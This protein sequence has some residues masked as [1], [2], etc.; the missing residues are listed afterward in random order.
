MTAA[1]VAR[2]HLAAKNKERPK[3]NPELRSLLP[4]LSDSERTK[5][6]NSI[7]VDG[8][9]EYIVVWQEQNV[10]VEGHNRQDICDEIK[11]SKGGFFVEPDGKKTRFE[12]DPD[13]HDPH[14]SYISF[15]DIDA[16]KAWMLDTQEGRRN[17]TELQR[18]Y[19]LGV[20]YKL[21]VGTRGGEVENRENVAEKMAGDLGVSSKTVENAAKFAE[22]IDKIAESNPDARD[23]ILSGDANA[24]VQDVVKLSKQ[25]N[26]VI[27]KA[28]DKIA[29][30]KDAGQIVDNLPEPPKKSDKPRSEPA[31]VKDR[32]G[33][34]V[35]GHLNRV[36]EKDT[37]DEIDA[38]IT[39]ANALA[40]EIGQ[41]AERTPGAKIRKIAPDLQAKARAIAEEL[42]AKAPHCVCDAC[43]GVKSDMENCKAC[44]GDGFI[45]KEVFDAK[46]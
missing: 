8:I 32:N 36:F 15:P 7:L 42:K 20:R 38:L 10:I 34:V 37:K 13:K 39:S 22:A 25:D 35:P 1:S 14:Y 21:K 16:A 40:R 17:L 26:K 19:F 46:K 30:G 43:K 23:A 28:A 11:R 18:K 3:V 33:K 24:S 27:E 31:K 45:S 4:A 41:L 5:L 6:K 2:E 44:G 29:E 12:Y 9:R